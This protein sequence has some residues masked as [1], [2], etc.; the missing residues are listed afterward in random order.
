MLAV[1]ILMAFS[2]LHESRSR[3]YRGTQKM[4]TSPKGCPITLG[5]H[6][7]Q[8]SVI[9]REMENHILIARHGRHQIRH[10]LPGSPHY[11]VLR[12]A[13]W[14]MIRL[15]FSV[16][17][18]SVANNTTTTFNLWLNIAS[19][20]IQVHKGD[21]AIHPLPSPSSKDRYISALQDHEHHAH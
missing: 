14:G 3:D 19:T 4:V 8:N 20:P 17:Q 7:Y 16:K 6:L 10:S 1:P 11:M 15:H 9:L 13:V 5:P 18:G 21:D 12:H 2:R